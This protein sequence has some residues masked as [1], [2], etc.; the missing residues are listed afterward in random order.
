MNDCSCGKCN[1]QW[2]EANLSKWGYWLCHGNRLIGSS[3][4]QDNSN[5]THDPFS[6]WHVQNLCW[7]TFIIGELYHCMYSNVLDVSEWSLQWGVAYI[8][9]HL[10]ITGRPTLKPRHIYPTPSSSQ[11]PNTWVKCHKL[12]TSNLWLAIRSGNCNFSFPLDSTQKKEVLRY[13]KY[14]AGSCQYN[15]WDFHVQKIMLLIIMVPFTSAVCFQVS[16]GENWR[17]AHTC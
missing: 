6:S 10:Q 15:E 14:L 4:V 2:W 16:R 7:L 3:R 9:H 17:R 5:S 8:W 1:E 13:L 12:H 11:Q